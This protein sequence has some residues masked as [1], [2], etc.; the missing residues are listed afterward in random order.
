MPVI[1]NG[2]ELSDADLE[3]E[4]PL[5]S[6]AG[7]PMREA[8]TALVLRR[9]LLDEA[10]RQGLDASDEEGA[11]GGLL[12]REAT[13]PEA[14]EAA[15]RRFY[16]M[17]PERFMVGELV[18]A[19]HILFQVTPSVNL[20][21]LRAHAD[22]VLAEL[23]EDPSRFAEV[24]REQSNCPSS[25]VGGSLGQLGRGDTVPEFERAVFALPAGGILPQLLQTRH[26]LHILRV[27]R[28]IE[29]RLLPYEHVAG[30]IATALSA[31]SR[32]IAWR[33]Y[34]KL[35]VG[36]ARIEGIDLEEGEPERVFSGSAA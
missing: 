11:I 10:S 15:C 2:V 27:T 12:A 13:A 26:G 24:A 4:L 17:H 6:E 21:M 1:V 34:V 30:Q 16:Q 28:R 3:R 9:V 29:G 31:M 7:N 18:E 25:A 19:D 36:R 22:V 8:V 14:D 33:Q 5:H 35:L 23:L 32:D 20:D